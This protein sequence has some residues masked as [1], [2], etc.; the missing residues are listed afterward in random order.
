MVPVSAR[1]SLRYGGKGRQEE[2]DLISSPAL[3]LGCKV[4]PQETVETKL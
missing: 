1:Q 4:D 3:L 2:S